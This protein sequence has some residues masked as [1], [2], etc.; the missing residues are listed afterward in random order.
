MFDIGFSELIV[1]AI[2][3]LVVVGPERMPRVARTAGLLLGRVQL[4]VNEVK[5]DISRE[6]QLDELIRLQSEMQESARNFERNMNQEIRSIE[7]N[8]QQSVDAV[9]SSLQE[10][11]AQVE[12]APPATPATGD[13]P[14]APLA[15]TTD[16]P[17]SNTDKA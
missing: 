10:I 17:P 6:I 11:A 7:A 8:V 14:A 2:V 5:A 16:Q 1:I 13:A 15:L 4:Y 3:T 12:D 9:Q